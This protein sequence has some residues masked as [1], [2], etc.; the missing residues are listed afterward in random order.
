[1]SNEDFKQT[2]K[3]KIK[4]MDPLKNVPEAQKKLMHIIVCCL[5]FPVRLTEVVLG[6]WLPASASS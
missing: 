6:T 3:R 1:M 2:N 5:Y 4:Q